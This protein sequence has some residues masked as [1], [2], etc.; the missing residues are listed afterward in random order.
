M[1]GSL[2]VR[3]DES[4]PVCDTHVESAD[5]EEPMNE[6]VD[7]AH[8]SGVT[9]GAARPSQLPGVIVQV[10]G[11]VALAEQRHRTIGAGRFFDLFHVHATEVT[12]RGCSR[13]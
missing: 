13:K 8:T 6:L 12:R 10:N 4:E 9:T 7:V 11:Q 2:A 3:P 5:R 1:S